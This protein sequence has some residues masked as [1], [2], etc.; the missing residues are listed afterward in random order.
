MIPLASSF[1]MSQ[2]DVRKRFCFLQKFEV[3]TLTFVNK[4]IPKLKIAYLNLIL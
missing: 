4:L 2:K 3:L 1:S